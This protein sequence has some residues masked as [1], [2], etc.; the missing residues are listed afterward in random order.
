MGRTKRPPAPTFNKYIPENFDYHAL[1]AECP[2]SFK[3]DEQRVYQILSL[4]YEIP[5]KAKNKYRNNDGWVPLHSR[6]VQENGVRK[7]RQY[8]EWLEDAEVIEVQKHYI[9]QHKAMRYRLKPEYR[10][11][12]RIVGIDKPTIVKA[13]ERALEKDTENTRHSHDYLFRWFEGLEI[14]AEGARNHLLE[15]Y[16]KEAL[17]GEPGAIDR[18]NA[19]IVHV[20]KIVNKQW[21][22]KTDV[23][24][25]R[26][27]HNLSN[28]KSELRNF[29]RW[30][31]KQL[32]S[33][34]IRNSQPVMSVLLLNPKFWME[35][36][37]MPS[38]SQK[39]VSDRVKQS[40][41]SDFSAKIGLNLPLF[42]LFPSFLPLFPSFSSISH[43]I[44]DLP[45]YFHPLH[46][47]TRSPFKL[48]V[49]G[50]NDAIQYI[51][52]VQSGLLYEEM[53]KTLI[54]SG[55]INTEFT[56]RRKLKEMIFTVMFT[57][58]RFIGQPEAM[59]KKIFQDL[60][61]SV[62]KIFAYAKRSNKIDLPLLLQKIESD[63]I[64]KKVARRVTKERRDLPIFTIHDSAIT[65]AGSEDFMLEVLLDE[66]QKMIGIVP[67]VEV[68]A[69]S[70]E[71]L[72]G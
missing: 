20:D 60:Y 69:W 26:L 17:A 47:S 18:Y 52:S 15:R 10:T 27:H 38:R 31:G 66:I 53:E 41:P 11:P 9:P 37:E 12:V 22:F 2:P 51:Q 19:G 57:S 71:N 36:E 64:L 59:P 62:D 21:H 70:P 56:S 13:I 45:D 1:V 33:L 23:K 24:S 46:L 3:T 39:L 32:V 43:S 40:E 5:A 48:G 6:I 4:F 67:E 61:P 16:R 68:V 49:F 55:A 29:V 72:M 28:M 42:E 65:T 44:Y 58:N 50:L 54:S 8:R 25:D 34:D 14:D 63:L 35:K 7:L 30:K